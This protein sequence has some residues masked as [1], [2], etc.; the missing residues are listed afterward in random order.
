[1]DF[2]TQL[3]GL[4]DFLTVIYGEQMRLSTL[5]ESL[6]F[7]KSQIAS[8]REKHMEAVAEQFIDVVRKRLTWEEKDLWFR[9]LA[10]RFGLDGEPAS[11]I[12]GAARALNV[13][14]SYAAYAESEA[15]Q[16]CRYKTALEHFKKEL[17]R[18][19]LAELSQHGEKPNKE[20]VVGKLNRLSDLRAAVD[21]TR[22]DYETKRKAI[23]QK[24]QVEL[25]ALD[26]EYDP[27]LEAAENNATALEAE[28]K[29]D[30][31]LRGESVR[32]EQFQA[33][34]TRGR[35]SWDNE[36]IVK[37]AESHPDVLKFRK[38]GQPTVSL[39]VNRGARW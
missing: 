5:L 35:V 13:D 27:V 31:L 23:L 7:D 19:A 34:Y 10:R 21:L 39:R 14:P 17:H 16:K 28:I 24:V 26:E 2:K 8:L 32:N 1:M 20:T 22:M 37:Y 4:N 3:D 6:G 33:T 11:D 12:A 38:E 15:L 9:I 30:V 29:N 25:D 36:G 18:I